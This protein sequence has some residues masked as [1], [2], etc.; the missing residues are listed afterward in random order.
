MTDKAQASFANARQYLPSNRLIGLRTSDRDDEEGDDE[1]SVFAGRARLVETRQLQS[2]APPAMYSTSQHQPMDTMHMFPPPPTYASS[3]SLSSSSSSSA[4]PPFVP[5]HANTAVT[6]AANFT[7]DHNPYPMM[8]TG[9]RVSPA[10]PALTS[11]DN[12]HPSL[13]DQL[14]GFDG[15]LAAQMAGSTSVDS[16]QKYNDAGVFSSSSSSLSGWQGVSVGMGGG[17]VGDHPSQ[18]RYVHQTSAPAVPYGHTSSLGG[19]TRSSASLQDMAPGGHEYLS[20]VG[21]G[22]RMER[23][24]PVQSRSQNQS[25]PQALPNKLGNMPETWLSFVQQLDVPSPPVYGSR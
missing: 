12:V 2:S 14:N 1:L 20:S 21:L 8:G 16:M 5:E 11:F 9:V 22:V 24:G 4:F 13:V 3:S 18:P 6:P 25:Q 7:T 10:N 19:R 23:D 15:R 17:D